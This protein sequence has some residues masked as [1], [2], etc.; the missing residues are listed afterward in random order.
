MPHLVLLGDSIFDNAAYVRGGPDVVRQVRSALPRGWQASLLAVDGATTDRVLPQLARLPSDATHLIVSAGGNDALGESGLLGAPTRTVAA[1]VGL[2]AE[3]QDAFEASYRS[4]LE[5]VIALGLPTALCTIYDT[6]AS[7]P[8]HR[9][10]KAALS[11]FND[12][13]TRA[14]FAHR[15]PLIDLRLICNEESDYAN[16]IEP[17]VQGGAKI[18]AAIARLA[19]SPSEIWKR[20]IVFS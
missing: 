15:L 12:R 6:P 13:I 4:M 8:E 10:I 14:A 11:L 18:A 19:E 2:L 7:A 16:P 3:A 17:S 9:V 20:S 5:R 1:A